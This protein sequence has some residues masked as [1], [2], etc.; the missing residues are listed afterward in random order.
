MAH[1]VYCDSEIILLDDVLSDVDVRAG[2]HIVES[3]T[4]RILKDE[5]KI[6]AIRQLLLIGAVVIIIFRNGD[7]SAKV[8]TVDNLYA[9]N[10]NFEK[11]R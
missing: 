2:K 3:C 7:G 9:T 11:T 10:A 4:F 5:R 6:L 1:A 8:G